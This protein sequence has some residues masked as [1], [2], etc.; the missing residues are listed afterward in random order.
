MPGAITQIP[1][2]FPREYSQNWD[3]LVQQRMSKLKDRVTM[4]TVTGKERTFNQ[5]DSV[6]MIDKVGRA[7]VTQAQDAA[8]AMRWLRMKPKEIT[9]LLDEKDAD[10]LGQIA[11]PQSEV[12]QAQLMAYFRKIDDVI[13]DAIGGTAYS[14]EDGATAN[15]LSGNQLVAVD[16][17]GPGV[18]AANVGLNLAKI[19]TAKSVL[20]VNEVDDDEQFIFLY[21]QQQLDDL[22]FAVNQVSSADYNNVKTLVEGG[23][24]FYFMGFQFVKTQR[25]PLDTGTDIRTCYAYVKSA[26]KFAENA[27]KTH[28]DIRADLSHAIQIRSVADMGA[29]RMEEKKVV[30]IACDQSP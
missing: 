14:G 13:I 6:D 19:I 25:L 21:S 20:G 30:A 24:N 12:M 23:K 26:I 18:A 8:M 9:H 17:K 28:V 29:V 11:L 2:F 4:K 16:Y 15:T 5:L 27:R 7:A 3:H 10:Y 1:E 22:L